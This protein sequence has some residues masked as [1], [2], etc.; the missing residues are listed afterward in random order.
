MTCAILPCSY[1]VRTFQKPISVVVLV[2]SAPV[3]VTLASF[4][5]SCFGHCQSFESYYRQSF[6]CF[7][8][9]HSLL[10]MACMDSGCSFCT[11]DSCKLHV[12]VSVTKGFLHDRVVNPVQNPQTWRTGGLFFVWPLT[13]DLSGMG[14]PNRTSRGPAS[15]ALRF[16]GARKSPPPLQGGNLI[17]YYYFKF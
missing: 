5:L 6:W 9:R 10:P 15:I 13:F 3:V 8:S 12:A 2:L 17:F 7:H 14:A 11:D 4:R 1:I 16:T